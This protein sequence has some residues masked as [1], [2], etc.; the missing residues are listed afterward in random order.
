MNDFYLLQI[1]PIWILTNPVY[2][3]R[4]NCIEDFAKK[5]SIIGKILEFIE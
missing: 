1:P 4:S 3:I 5:S 2:I